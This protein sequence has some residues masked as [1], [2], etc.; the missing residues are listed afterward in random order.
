L[1]YKYPRMKE[2]TPYQRKLAHPLWQKK[3]LEVMQRDGFKCTNCQSTEDELHIHHLYY[4]PNTLP[5]D[6]PLTAY[7]TFCNTCHEIEEAKMKLIEAA[8]CN[9]AQIAGLM[10]NHFVYLIETLEKVAKSGRSV[11]NA[12]SV[13]E[14]FSELTK[15]QEI[16]LDNQMFSTK[17]F[18]C[19]NSKPK[20]NGKR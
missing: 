11:S 13:M 7:T 5:Q 4:L 12:I 3:R 2:K 9:R 19:S 20:K 1:Q 15:D 10:S 16:E 18:S 6:Y 14:A 17:I 8:F